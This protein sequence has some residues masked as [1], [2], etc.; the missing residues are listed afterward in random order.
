MCGWLTIT[1]WAAGCRRAQMLLSCP[2]LLLGTARA[3]A[4]SGCCYL[5][6]PQAHAPGPAPP[7]KEHI[8]GAV[9]VPMF[10][11]TA[12]N[13]GW[14]NVKRVSSRISGACWVVLATDSSPRAGGTAVLHRSLSGAVCILPAP[15]AVHPPCNSL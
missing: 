15:L 12:G 9:S 6:L 2:A 5:Q 7:Q 14:D 3:A 10:R 13:S 11:L 4:S 8:D 1:R